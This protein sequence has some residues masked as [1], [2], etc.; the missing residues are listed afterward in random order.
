MS[1]PCVLGIVM[2]S[3]MF[4]VW[5]MQ[6]MLRRCYYGCRTGMFPHQLGSDTCAHGQ[7]MCLCKLTMSLL[8]SSAFTSACIFCLHMYRQWS[9]FLDATIASRLCA[10]HKHSQPHTQ[11]VCTYFNLHRQYRQALTGMTHADRCK[12]CGVSAAGSVLWRKDFGAEHALTSIKVDPTDW[13]HMCLCG[14][15]G[16]I[17]VLRLVNL[18]RDKVEQQT[19]KVDMSS[20]KPGDTLR[21]CFSAT[22]DL[23]YVLL[24]RE[25]SA[26]HAQHPAT[27]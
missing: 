9:T 6:G 5:D 20:S 10:G 17:I 8:A 24:P 16:S 19:Y 3:G 22:R 1:N 2:T 21:C 27:L 12:A 7:L 15:K 14:A 13:R 26:H 25:V 11:S 23:L 18:G 4:L